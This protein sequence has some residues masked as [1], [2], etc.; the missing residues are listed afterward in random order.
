M[1]SLAPLQQ[2]WAEDRGGRHFSITQVKIASPSDTVKLPEG[3]NN[4]AFVK[5]MV[6]DSGDTVATVSSITQAAHPEGVTVNLSGGTL[7][8]VQYIIA[9]HHGNTAGL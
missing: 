5:A 2:F 9:C 8:S 6:Q 7:G 4:V 1:A 3:V